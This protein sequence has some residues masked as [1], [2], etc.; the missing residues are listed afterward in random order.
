MPLV[1]LLIPAVFT[2]ENTEKIF[3]ATGKP[4]SLPQR[5]ACG[6]QAQRTQGMPKTLRTHRNRMTE[7]EL[8]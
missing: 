2:A 7:R 4:W 5:T 3:E 6:R 8:N 1:F